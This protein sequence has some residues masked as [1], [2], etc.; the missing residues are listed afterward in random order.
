M[1][2]IKCPH[3]KVGLKVDETRIPEGI[4]SFKCPK[5]KREIPLTYLDRKSGNE[6]D[7][8]TIVVASKAKEAEIGSLT[9]LPDPDTMRQEYNL[10]EGALIVGRKA[11][12]SAANICIDT[13]DKTMSRSHIRIEVKKKATGGYIHY[14]SDN[15]SKNH[16]LYNGKR[17]ES[18]EVVVLKNNDEIVIGNTLIR[19]NE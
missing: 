18:G 12:V 1:I 8:D 16:T 5:C 9:V 3:C 4:V 6:N 14:L 10:Y 11:K 17:I 19:F 7:A 2:P 13:N 15:N